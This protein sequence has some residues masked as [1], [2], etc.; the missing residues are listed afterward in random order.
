MVEYPPNA[1]RTDDVP[2]ANAVTPPH[3]EDLDERSDHLGT[4]CTEPLALD[5]VHDETFADNFR[6]HR[7]AVYLL[8]SRVCGPK[9]AGDVTQ[10]VFLRLWRDPER[11]DPARGSLRNFLLA[12]THH[13][14]I[15][16]VRSEEARRAREERASRAVD[17]SEVELDCELLQRESAGR[18]SEALDDLAPSERQAIV[19]AFYGHRSYREAAILLGE[20]EGTIKSRIRSGLRQL[21]ITL[22]DHPAVPEARS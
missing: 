9:H 17:A 7:K 20:P 1:V 12:I 19:A 21:R 13:K 5:H 18:I 3:G 11:F 4:V 8:A 14:A 16:A 22:A 15:D 2:N 6:D 10:E